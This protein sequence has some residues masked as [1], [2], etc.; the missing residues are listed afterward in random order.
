MSKGIEKKV[1]KEERGRNDKETIEVE[2]VNGKLN[3][4]RGKK[5]AQKLSGRSKKWRIAGVEN[6]IFRRG[7]RGKLSFQADSV[8]L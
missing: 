7:R 2:R 4:E 5:Y 1:E 6:I 8:M 3:P